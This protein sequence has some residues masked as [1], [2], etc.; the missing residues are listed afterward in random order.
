MNSAKIVFLYTEI[1]GYFLACAKSLSQSAE[2]LVV[3]WPVN[4]EAPFQLD[5]DG[6]TLLNRHDFNDQQLIKK[7]QEFNPDLIVC[8]G[9]MDKGYL[10]VAKSFRK[11]IP[12]VLSL[13]NHWNGTLKQRIACLVS[14]VYLKRI[15]T[16]AWVPG[17]PQAAYASRLG[18]GKNILLNYYCADTNLFQAVF[19]KTI[20]AKRKNFPH[21]FLYVARYV[22]HKGIFEL[23]QAFAEL[24]QETNCD[25]ELLC[26]GTGDQW[27]HRM[28]HERIQHIGF[29]QPADLEKYIAQSGVYI[30]P[31]KFEPWGVTVQEFAVA[32]FPLLLSTA[33]GARTKYLE[34]NGF[35]FEPGNKDEL[36]NAM[37]KIIS[38]SN[39]DLI[40]MAEQSHAL[41]ISVTP[42]LWSNQLLTL[43][44]K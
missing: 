35:D 19:D 25:W 16:H 36:K 44:Q 10:A 41:G 8:S 13:D 29:V 39:A 20:D 4:K 21:K 3:R 43:I 30:L 40:Q 17:K 38:Q 18:F 27:E 37:K 42:A 24:V 14:P 31:S 12:V 5:N 11:K 15:F 28:I 33:V 9:W 26:I 34:K 7:I 2:V 1:A 22:E 6:V 23:W 32:G